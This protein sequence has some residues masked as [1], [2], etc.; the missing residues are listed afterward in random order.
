MG[1]LVKVEE[2]QILKKIVPVLKNH[3]QI[4]GAY[5]FGSALEFCRPDSDIDIGLVMMPGFDV[6]EK[7]LYLLEARIHKDLSP[8]AGHHFDL[9]FLTLRDVFFSHKAIRTGKLIYARDMDVVTDFTE[10]V[11][12]RYRENYPRYRQALEDIALGDSK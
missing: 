2:V 10:S 6:S 8:L 11:S 1:G 12:N 3:E 9:V 4:A 5:L 7:E